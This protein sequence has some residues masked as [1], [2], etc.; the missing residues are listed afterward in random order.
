MLQA[1]EKKLYPRVFLRKDLAGN[2][3][4]PERKK[5]PMFSPKMIQNKFHQSACKIYQWIEEDLKCM[6]PFEQKLVLFLL[7]RYIVTKLAKIFENLT[8]Y[9]KSMEQCLEKVICFSPEKVHT[10]GLPILS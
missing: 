7:S 4:S 2:G 3:S 1:A 9:T 10:K 6:E 8:F 5:A